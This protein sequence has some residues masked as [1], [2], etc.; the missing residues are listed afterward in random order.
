[1]GK[2]KTLRRFIPSLAELLRNIAN[3]LKKETK[4]KCTIEEKHSFDE[5]LVEKEVNGLLLSLNMTLISK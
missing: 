4:I 5:V 1:M 2:I 3:M